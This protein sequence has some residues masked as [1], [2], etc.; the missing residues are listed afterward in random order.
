MTTAITSPAKDLFTDV[1]ARSNGTAAAA[2]A[3]TTASAARFLKML[4]TQLQNQDPLNP[5]DNAQ[6][7]SQM[8]QI[9]A[10]TGLEKVN[11]SVKALNTQLLQMQALQGAGLVG[12]DVSMEGNLMSIADGVGRGAVELD[13]KATSVKVEVLDGSGKVVD[14]IDLGVRDAGVQSFNWNP[15]R[16]P[17]D[18]SYT[19]RA[20]AANG[21]VAV[22]GRTLMLD[23]VLSVST[24]GDTLNL[25]LARHGTVPASQVLAFN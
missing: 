8:A 16:L 22:S 20:A 2:A 15:G 19:F 10:V 23:R 1:A 9:N 25:N 12:R 11:Q 13:G 4:V 5:M 14:T 17:T 7:T 3:D 21:G 24:A 18:A 6:L